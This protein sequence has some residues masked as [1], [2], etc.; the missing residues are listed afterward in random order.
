M[1]NR[2]KLSFSNETT[3]TLLFSLQDKDSPA[4]T[5]VPLAPNT[6][7]TTPDVQVN[8]TVHVS[9]CTAEKTYDLPSSRAETVFR[10]HI[11]AKWI[12]DALPRDCPWRIY[13][14]KVPPMHYKFMHAPN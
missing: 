10:L 14:T 3:D 2:V 6:S 13:R 5:A 4:N 12:V 7:V 11:G 8:A 1:R 9:L